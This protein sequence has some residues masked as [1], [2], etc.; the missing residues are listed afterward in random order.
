MQ[1]VMSRLRY[2]IVLLGTL[3]VLTIGVFKMSAQT[4]RQAMDAIRNSPEGTYRIGEGC[5]DNEDDAQ[6][7]AMTAL[8]NSMHTVFGMEKNLVSDSS[9]ER[10]MSLTVRAR[11]TI[12]L[13]RVS[14]LSYEQDG[15]WYCMC[16]VPEEEIVKAIEARKEH[17]TELIMLGIEQ[18][19]KLNIAGAL[20]YYNWALMLLS[21]YE[22][23]MKIDLEGELRDPRP[24]L[25]NHI[26]VVLDNIS[27]TLDNDK[28]EY[29]DRDYDHYSFNLDINYAGKP[30]SAI[31]LSY[32]NG[33]RDVRPIHAKNGLG[34][35]RFPDVES[36]NELSI[37]IIYD[38]P[39]DVESYD[40]QLKAVYDAGLRQRFQ[41]RDR[42]RI[43]VKINKDRI[44]LMANT[45]RDENA[46]T[47]GETAPIVVAERRT[48]E[49]PVVESGQ[50][51]KV[52]ESVEA[53]LRGRTYDDLRP[54]FTD[55]GWDLFCRMTS[56]ADIRVV[57][58][59]D[60][61]NVEKS[62]FFC[63]G[64]GIPVSV[65]MGGHHSNETIV[66]RF[67]V[68]SGLIAS[69]AYALTERAENDIFR[70][71]QWSLDSRYSLLT[72]MEDYQTAFALRRLD[73]IESIFSDD[74]VIITG[75]FNDNKPSKRFYDL[76]SLNLDNRTVRYSKMDKDTYMR[77]LKGYF[78]P[79]SKDFRKY[80]QLVFEDAV[81][82]KAS[83]AGFVEDREIMW[84]E[85]K[86]QYNSDKYNDKGFLALQIDLKPTGSQIHVRTWTPHFLP[87]E[88]LKKRFNI[89]Y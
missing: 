17:I 78:D 61:Y 89:G 62:R 64:R 13:D 48:I 75:S 10:S 60:T 27:I 55:D 7:K 47:S 80:I 54:L 37:G 19:G 9:T 28:I 6:A 70:E 42:V 16:Y 31:D 23:N 66:F 51:V 20:K 1:R 29:D 69:V 84:I 76:E 56:L 34:T 72:F 40:S 43:P 22:D 88:V 77:H 45:N 67:D 21:A 44:K 83:T 8:L 65:K 82:S 52:M 57:K 87:L 5:A 25:K 11:T 35:L 24:W 58:T 50:L 39:E 36:I 41:G 81:I 71:S 63:I 18:E 74:A 85:I 79:R 3:F 46:I 59:P 49:R 33:V 2:P 86:Q 14:T 26:P 53:G 38:Y 32:F 15:Y 73:Y 12:A 4:Q 68:E 30:V